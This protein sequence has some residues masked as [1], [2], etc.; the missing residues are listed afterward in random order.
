M[1]VD[2]LHSNYRPQTTTKLSLPVTTAAVL[3]CR[4]GLCASARFK[5]MSRKVR[6]YYYQL[7]FEV[8]FI[9]ADKTFLPFSERISVSS[10]FPTLRFSFALTCVGHY[11]LIIN[12]QYSHAAHR[13]V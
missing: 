5:I 9:Q 4:L 8:T 10:I 1:G 12:Q 7:P 3:H 2:N 11:F 13:K 6:H